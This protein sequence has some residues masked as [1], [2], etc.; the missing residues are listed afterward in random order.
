MEMILTKKCIEKENLS[1]NGVYEN[2]NG[3][4]LRKRTSEWVWE[5]CVLVSVQEVTFLWSTNL[6][7]SIGS[8]TT[9]RQGS[10]GH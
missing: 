1:E 9:H 10:R 2:K 8:Y 3:R 5:S 7:F 4:T 6:V